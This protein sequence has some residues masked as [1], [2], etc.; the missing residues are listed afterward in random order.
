MCL[1]KEVIGSEEPQWHETSCEAFSKAQEYKLAESPPFKLPS[2]VRPARF[3]TSD[4]GTAMVEFNVVKGNCM[5]TD[6]ECFIL[7]VKDATK[8]YAPRVA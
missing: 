4:M 1:G 6:R 3:L 8:Y 2:V 5:F 7:S